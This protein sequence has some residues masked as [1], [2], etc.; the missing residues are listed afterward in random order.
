MAGSELEVEEFG[1]ARHGEHGDGS[2]QAD[3]DGPAGGVAPGEFVREPR[4]GLELVF[5]APN[6]YFNFINTTNNYSTLT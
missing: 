2:E 3:A 1:D 4:G 5:G 6:S